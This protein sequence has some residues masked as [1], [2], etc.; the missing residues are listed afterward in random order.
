MSKPGHEGVAQTDLRGEPPGSLLLQGKGVEEG[1]IAQEVFSLQKGEESLLADA[2]QVERLFRLRQPEGP[3]RI[4]AGV[5]EVEGPM[6]LKLPEVVAFE[7]LGGENQGE[8]DVEKRGRRE[9]GSVVAAEEVGGGKGEGGDPGVQSL[10]GGWGGKLQKDGEDVEGVFSEHLFQ[11][12]G[13]RL[14]PTSA[15]GKSEV[16]G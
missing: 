11:G 6:F 5:R 3:L 8:T 9:E 14:L 12:R 7:N 4:F 2:F 16:E 1:Q 10:S 13:E 15:R